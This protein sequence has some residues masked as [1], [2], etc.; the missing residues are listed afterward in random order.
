[1]NAFSLLNNAGAD[2]KIRTCDP[3]RVKRVLYR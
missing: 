1:M 2:Y 3:T